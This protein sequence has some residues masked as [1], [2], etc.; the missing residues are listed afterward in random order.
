MADAPLSKT[1]I[2]VSNLPVQVSNDRL[3]AA[4]IKFGPITD[5]FVPQRKRF[6]FVTFENEADMKK[7]L[8]MDGQQLDEEAAAAESEPLKITVAREKPPA[9]EGEHAP[10]KKAPAKKAPVKKEAPAK[11][12]PVAKGGAKGEDGNKKRTKKAP[13]EARQKQTFVNVEERK[14]NYVQEIPAKCLLIGYAHRVAEKTTAEYDAANVREGFPGLEWIQTALGAKGLPKSLFFSSH[15]ATYSS[16]ED[17]E[18]WEVTVDGLE[19][20]DGKQNFAWKNTD[21]CPEHAAK[22]EDLRRALLNE[23]K[24]SMSFD[25][26]E[27]ALNRAKIFLLNKL[28]NVGKPAAA[29]KP[30]A[31]KEAP[32][33]GAPAGAKKA[34]AVAAVH[35]KGPASGLAD[36]EEFDLDKQRAAARSKAAEFAASL[37]P[38]EAAIYGAKIQKAASGVRPDSDEDDDGGA[39]FCVGGADDA[40]LLGD[41]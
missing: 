21:A 17:G 37:T 2:Y 8:S 14:A 27:I 15:T 10:A 35:S 9:P 39:N 30:A 6:G 3:K 13:V 16:H 33:V 38:E 4:F 29:P 12:A 7:A 1:Q 22:Y 19:G 36:G 5:N 11:K 28:S 26:D 41:Y 24:Y 25:A 18:S 20:E 31:A 32:A 34:A 40:V 23:A